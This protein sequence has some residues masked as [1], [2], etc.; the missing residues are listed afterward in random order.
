MTTEREKSDDRVVPEGRRKAV[1]TAF[2]TV[3]GRREGRR[4]RRPNRMCNSDFSLRQQKSRDARNREQTPMPERWG[5]YLPLRGA[6]G[7]RQGK[8]CGEHAQR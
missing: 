6:R 7:R 2:R 1:P 5:T 3:E 8:R 4:S